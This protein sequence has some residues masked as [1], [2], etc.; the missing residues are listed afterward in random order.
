M[1][2]I[3][4]AQTSNSIAIRLVVSLSDAHTHQRAKSIEINYALT[5]HWINSWW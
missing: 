3:N 2:Q 1:G 4:L 5:K